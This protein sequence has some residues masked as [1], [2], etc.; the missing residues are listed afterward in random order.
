MSDKKPTP[1]DVLDTTKILFGKH[2]G[3]TPREVA[4]EDPEYVVWMYDECR[5]A[6]CSKDLA[7]L[8]EEGPK[9]DKVSRRYDQDAL[10]E[11]A[12]DIAENW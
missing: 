6:P 5:P 8:C 7:L 11:W 2:K 12:E 9:K 3:K 4:Q 10:I 1:G